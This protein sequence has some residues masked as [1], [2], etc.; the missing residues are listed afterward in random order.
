[1]KRNCCL[2]L[3]LSLVFAFILSCASMKNKKLQPGLYEMEFSTSDYSYA[4]SILKGERGKERDDVDKSDIRFD[5]GFTSCVEQDGIMARSYIDYVRDAATFV[6]RTKGGAG[7]YASIGVAPGFDSM[8]DG[9]VSKA[10]KFDSYYK[11]LPFV[12]VD[13]INEKGVAVSL[14]SYPVSDFSPEMVIDLY[15]HGNFSPKRREEMV[16]NMI[17]VKEEKSFAERLAEAAVLNSQ[18]LEESGKEPADEIFVIMSVRYLLDKADSVDSAVEALKKVRILDYPTPDDKT[19]GYHYMIADESKCV[20]VEF[21]DGRMYVDEDATVM[22]DYSFNNL[23]SY[24]V[25]GQERYDLFKERRRGMTSKRAVINVMKDLYYSKA[26]DVSNPNSFWYSECYSDKGLFMF[27]PPSLEEI[28]ESFDGKRFMYDY[29][30]EVSEN[31]KNIRRI[32]SAMM[33]R[34]KQ[35][36]I[37]YSAHVSV[38]DI[39]NRSLTLIAR[40]NNIEYDFKI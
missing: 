12:L 36:N 21:V 24:S 22:T 25:M 26:Y 20:C 34:Q 33:N 8:N 39:K 5:L 37:L 4:M 28:D 13:G 32:I 30:D 29:F 19:R 11:V 6:I 17:K 9:F 27:N 2:L 3:A 14:S 16:R 7:R 31:Q 40:E 38:Y 15:K 1:M 35:N 10:L 23:G 18:D